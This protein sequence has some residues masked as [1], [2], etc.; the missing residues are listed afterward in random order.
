MPQ[1]LEADEAAKKI[2][3]GLENS[4]NFEI[5]FPFILTRVLQILRTLH[6]YIAFYFTKKAL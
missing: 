1:L 3:M 6:Y 2:Y 5:K 4:D